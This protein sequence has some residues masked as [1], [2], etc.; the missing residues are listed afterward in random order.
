[1]NFG[2]TRYLID[3]AVFWHVVLEWCPKYWMHI[4]RFEFSLV[5]KI[6]EWQFWRGC[7]TDLAPDN[8]VSL[9]I[10]RWYPYILIDNETPLPLYSIH[11][12]IEPFNGVF[13]TGEYYIDEYVIDKR[14]GK[15]SKLKLVSIANRWYAHWSQSLR[16]PPLMSNGV[17]KH[18]KH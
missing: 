16:C 3:L 4:L 7:S 18:V 13:K 14:L 6:Q 1:M 17:S 2:L 8:L 12:I 9:D 10:S 11:D 5:S 15:G